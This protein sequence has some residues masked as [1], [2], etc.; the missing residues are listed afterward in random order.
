VVAGLLIWLLNTRY[1]IAFAIMVC[2]RVM[3]KPSRGDVKRIKRLARYINCHKDRG[4]NFHKALDFTKEIISYVY[5]DASFNISVVTGVAL[6]CG[7]PDEASHNNASAAIMVLVKTE[8]VAVTSTM[9]AE[10][11]AI[12]RSVVALEWLM[13]FREEAGFPQTDPGIIFTDSLS[14]IKYIE[15]TGTAPNRQTRHLKRRVA[16]I[17]WAVSRNMVVFKFVPGSMNCADV[18]TKPLGRVLHF[19]HCNNLQGYGGHYD[20]AND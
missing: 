1:D 9:E 15:N 5:C 10:L 6:F 20:P 11:L 4:L 12:E 14:A 19:K 17:K 13:H 16:K 7:V 18:L 3:S 2:C 8:K